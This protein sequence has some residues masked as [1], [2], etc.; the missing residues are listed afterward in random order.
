M[1]H[2]LKIKLNM[3]QFDQDKPIGNQ[4]KLLNKL[5]SGSFGEVYKGINMET[6]ELVAVKLVII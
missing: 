2:I 4:Y 6:N 1:T 3:L 5:G